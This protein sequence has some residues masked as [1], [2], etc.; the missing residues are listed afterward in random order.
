MRRMTPEDEIYRMEERIHNRK[1]SK[2]IFT[3]ED[4]NRVFNDEV[5]WYGVSE[6]RQGFRNDVW[7]KFENDFVAPPPPGAGREQVSMKRSRPEILRVSENSFIG[8]VKGRVSYGWKE[9]VTYNGKQAVRYRNRK[10]Q[11]VSVKKA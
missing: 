1:D 8:R 6:A 9:S 3:Q 7:K 4:F 5:E 2:Y 11:F 10:G